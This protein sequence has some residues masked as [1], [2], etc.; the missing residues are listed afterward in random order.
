MALSPARYGPGLLHP[1]APPPM[2]NREPTPKQD[3]SDNDGKNNF[4]INYLLPLKFLV[5]GVS[6]KL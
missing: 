4:Y 3:S 2:L 5:E 6:F 1:V